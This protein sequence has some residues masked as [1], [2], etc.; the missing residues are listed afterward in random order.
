ML[1]KIAMS[2]FLRCLDYYYYYYY[3]YYDIGDF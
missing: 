3:Y 1:F 2:F